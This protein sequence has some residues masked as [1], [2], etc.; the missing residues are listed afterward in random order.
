ML[1]ISRFSL[2]FAVALQASA[3]ASAQGLSEK[4]WAV[5]AYNLHG[6]STPTALPRPKTLSPY[7]ASELYASGSSFRDHYVAIHSDGNVGASTRIQNLSPYVL[8]S[9]EVVVLSTTEQAIVASAQA[10][11]QGL[12]PPLK[13]SGNM[14][15]VDS[16]S[17]LAN[18]SLAMAPF[19]GYQYPR[20]STLS[21][22]DPHSLAVAGHDQ[23]LA[24][25]VKSSE[26]QSSSEFQQMTQVTE[27]FYID[28]HDQALSGVY[29]RSSASYKNAV[30]IAEY[31]EYEVVHNETL[32]HVLGWDDIQHARWLADQY[33]FATNGRTTSGQSTT[34]APSAEIRTIAGRTLASR[35]LEAFNT[36]IQY[37]GANEKLTLAFGGSEPVVALA[38]LMKLAS[39]YGDYYPHPQ[40]GASMIFELYS[41]ENATYPVYPDSSELYVRFLLHNGTSPSTGFTPYPLFG[42]GPSSIAI[43]YNEFQ[44]E[45]EQYAIRSTREW[46]LKCEST[47][48]FCSGVL[49][50]N[51]KASDSDDQMDPTVAGG[52]GAVV[53][54]VVYTLGI[55]F[56]FLLA[57]LRK[58]KPGPGGFKKDRK[59]ASDTDVTFK[60]PVWG[61][62]KTE[63]TQKPGDDDGN[64]VTISPQE[65]SGSWEMTE[66]KERNAAASP[67]ENGPRSPFSDEIEEEVLIHSAVEPA[68]VR[69]SV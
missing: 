26:Y 27:A 49:S 62:S 38:S 40:P 35:I 11:M 43:P 36:N 2:A 68:K 7:G 18:G 69:E 20:I 4:V 33:L 57:G 28:L 63:A 3:L 44:A 1:A 30:D 31:L 58:R 24:H 59:M 51:K 67:T 15:Y 61:D 19:Q 37:R 6:D 23:C 56:V 39:R 42:H 66:N 34:P 54:L 10:F 41:L 12:Y 8:D 21:P 53:T 64:G 17:L 45:M 60:N 25:Q 65:R 16:S 32:L 50:K 14:T 29:D 48:V 46:C 55:I 9:E 5:F 13:Q 52:I 22:D 47:A